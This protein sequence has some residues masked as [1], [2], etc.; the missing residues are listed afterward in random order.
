MN[1]T[2]DILEDTLLKKYPEAFEVLLKDRTTDRNI[3]WA[4]HD[5]EEMGDG[6]QYD[7]EIQSRNITGEHG[8]VIKPRA[9]KHKDIQAQRSK[10][11][12]EVFTPSWVCNLQNN[13]VDEAWFGRSDVFNREILL[14]DNTHT[15]ETNTEK[16]SFENVPESRT[17]RDYIHDTRIEITCGEAPYLASRY[18]TTSGEFIPI[19]NRIGLLDRKLRV[20]SENCD[21]TGLWLEMAQ[22]AFKNIYGYEWQGDNLLIARES[23]LYSFIEYYN[24]K[25]GR[26]PLKRSVNAIAEIISWNIWQMDGLKMVVPNSCD[27]VYASSLFGEE[28]C[29]CPACEKGE[30]Y[31]HIGKQCIIKNWSR[32]A[33]KQ[34][35]PFFTLFID[36]HYKQ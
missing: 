17:W 1:I 21:E 32:P 33:E 6:F 35:I 14:D 18:D 3:F 20:V 9:L 15:W 27:K 4:T 26:L 25:F 24:E 7:D 30:Y 36:K 2:V 34:N 8:Q 16:V 11:M 10:D 19:R 28:K 29:N 5:Y 12:A 13:L 22:E 31:G 23:L